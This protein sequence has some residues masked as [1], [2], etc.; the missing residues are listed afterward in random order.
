MSTKRTSTAVSSGNNKKPAAKRQKTSDSGDNQPEPATATAL[1]KK[2]MSLAD[3]FGIPDATPDEVT[4]LAL[5]ESI[6]VNAGLDPD[7]KLNEAET[8]LLY[9]FSPCGLCDAAL[10]EIEEFESYTAT[11]NPFDRAV[12]KQ[13][14]NRTILHLTEKLVK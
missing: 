13:I 11:D 3:K 14:M 12:Y 4:E 9:W 1:V 7:I 6:I 2:P 10:Q 5:V 8:I